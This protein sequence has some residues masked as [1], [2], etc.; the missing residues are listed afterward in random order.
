MTNQADTVTRGGKSW[1]DS[2]ICVA[3]D[4]SI[5]GAGGGPAHILT[6]HQGKKMINLNR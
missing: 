1:G 4:S 5:R 2:V 3:S 6:Q